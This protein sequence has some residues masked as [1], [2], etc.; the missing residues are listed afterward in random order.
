VAT[1]NRE[2][3]IETFEP[4]RPAMP[5]TFLFPVVNSV[6][7]DESDQHIKPLDP[8]FSESGISLVADRDVIVPRCKLTMYITIQLY[9][10]SCCHLPDF[11]DLNDVLDEFER[12]HD[13][14]S[15]N[16]QLMV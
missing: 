7:R 8:S 13:F 5:N 1:V 3:V 15:L 11:R 6:S 12:V 10:L 4:S 16:S 2:T 9:F 14:V